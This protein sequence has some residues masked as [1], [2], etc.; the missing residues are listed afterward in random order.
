MAY[1]V[2]TRELAQAFGLGE[3]Q[4]VNL[5]HQGMPKIA[6]G[7]YDLVSCFKWKVAQLESALEEARREHPEEADKRQEEALLA[8]VRREKIEME[9]AERRGL[10]LEADKVGS[11]LE[12]AVL[13]MRTKLLSIPT[14]SAPRVVAATGVNEVKIILDEVVH[15]ALSELS[16]VSDDVAALRGITQE[17]ISD[18]DTPSE[19]DGE[20]MG[21]QRAVSKPRSKRRARKVVHG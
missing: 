16:R 9:N 10:L 17:G 3:R 21:G 18:D 5:W 7:R 2:T 14:K 8:R 6:V 13:F 12:R 1:E 20:P 11:V 4:I 15:D 19:A